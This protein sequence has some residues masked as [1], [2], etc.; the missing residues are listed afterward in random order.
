MFL[1]W[2]VRNDGIVDMG[3]WKQ[4]SPTQLIIPLDTHVYKLAFALGIT[5]RNTPD[6]QSAIENGPILIIKYNVVILRSYNTYNII[7]QE[8][9]VIHVGFTDPQQ[10]YRKH[11]YFGSV[12]A[13]Y[14]ILPKDIVGISKEALWSALKY[15]EY[16]GR[17][18]IIRRGV[19]ISK[20][21]KR[22]IRKEK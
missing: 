3:I 10:G 15:G 9:K 6:M 14:D 13:I 21:T 18:A 20:Q 7:K 19:I 4:I 16:R 2:M 8:R 17:K 22:G 1:R 11:Y 5:K 12:A